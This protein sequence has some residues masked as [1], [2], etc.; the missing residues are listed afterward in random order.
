MG[1]EV[2]LALSRKYLSFCQ[3]LASDHADEVQ[4]PEP[5]GCRNWYMGVVMSL[6]PTKNAGHTKKMC[7]FIKPLLFAQGLIRFS[8]DEATW[9]QCTHV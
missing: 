4:Q 7:R 9:I 3:F 5:S 1:V 8:Q 6:L 2:I